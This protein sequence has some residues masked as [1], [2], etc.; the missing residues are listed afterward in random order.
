MEWIKKSK[1]MIQATT[2]YKYKHDE[3]VGGGGDFVPIEEGVRLQNFII[4]I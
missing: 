3:P 4:S 1:V 2:A